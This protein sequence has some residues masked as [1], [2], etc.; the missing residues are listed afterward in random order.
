MCGKDLVPTRK[1]WIECRRLLATLWTEGNFEKI[2]QH[3]GVIVQ[4]SPIVYEDQ[5]YQTPLIL[6]ET[7]EKHYVKESLMIKCNE[8]DLEITLV[9]NNSIPRWFTM[10]APDSP[11]NHYNDFKQENQFSRK[12]VIEDRNKEIDSDNSEIDDKHEDTP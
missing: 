2:C 8:V 5:F 1:N 11:Y 12:N 10:D 6:V 9:E 3:L 7:K 4:H